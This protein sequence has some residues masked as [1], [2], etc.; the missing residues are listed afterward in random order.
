[1]PDR[2]VP[3][4]SSSTRRTPGSSGDP[5]SSG[6]IGLGLGMASLPKIADILYQSA[7]Y[8]K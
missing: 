5:E 8:G 6:R 7:I 2:S 1:M 3:K 4:L